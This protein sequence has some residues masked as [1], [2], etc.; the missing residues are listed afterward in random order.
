V[1]R[2]KLF[3]SISNGGDDPRVREAVLREENT[4]LREENTRLELECE[5][6]KQKY[7]A[8]RA[9]LRD[10]TGCETPSPRAQAAAARQMEDERSHG[11]TPQQRA[12]DRGFREG[13]ENRAALLQENPLLSTNGHGNVL[14]VREN[15]IRRETADERFE[16]QMT[17]MRRDNKRK[18]GLV[19]FA[20]ISMFV[21]V[22]LYLHPIILTWILDWEIK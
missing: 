2:I 17:Q 18:A 21:T 3:R 4:W 10:A 22:M 14:D 11:Q 8:A 12:F 9:G 15:V 7:S 1:R 16:R 6:L 19:V 13:Q 5:K 20:C